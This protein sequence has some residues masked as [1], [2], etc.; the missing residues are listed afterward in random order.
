MAGTTVALNIGTIHT[1][2]RTLNRPYRRCGMGFGGKE[3]LTQPHK[4]TRGITAKMEMLGFG[5]MFRWKNMVNNRPQTNQQRK[6]TSNF[7]A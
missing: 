1:L 4:I 7:I 3:D 2:S 6:I 5:R